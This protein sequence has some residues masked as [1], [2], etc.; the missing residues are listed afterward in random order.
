MAIDPIIGGS[1]I[2][3]A[4][5]IF[6]GLLGSSSSD[7]ARKA[8]QAEAA[9]DRKLQKQFAKK[10]IRWRVEDAQA[11]GIHPLYAMGASIP[12]YTPSPARLGGGDNSMGNALASAGQDIGR[13]VSATMTQP[14]RDLSLQRS[15][16][17]NKLL[18]AQILK[19]TRESQTGPPLPSASSGGMPGQGNFP[20]SVDVFPREITASSPSNVGRQAGAPAGISYVMGSDQKLRIYPSTDTKELM[21]D[22]VFLEAKWAY[23]NMAKPLWTRDDMRKNAPST[24]EFPLPPGF[25]WQWNAYAQAYEKTPNSHKRIRGA[26]GRNLYR[27]D[28]SKSGGGW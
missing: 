6:G 9:A 7:K 21:E 13:A 24:D 12:G 4:A 3:G 23:Q 5:S 16:L 2:S 25:H 17:Q 18:E 14:E 8:A 28:R 26:R 27:P 22:N 1:L 11:A 20:S 19:L 10:G 15:A